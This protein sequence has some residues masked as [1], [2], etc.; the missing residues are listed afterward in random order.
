MRSFLILI[1][2]IIAATEITADTHIVYGGSPVE[3]ATRD[4]PLGIQQKLQHVFLEQCHPEL[5]KARSIKLI[6]SLQ[7][8]VVM[9][10]GESLTVYKL[11]LE[12]ITHQGELEY[13]KLTLTYPDLVFPLA[14]QIEVSELRSTGICQ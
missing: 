8:V 9:G 5:G 10:L 12:V 4:L 14:E 7:E 2:F 6:K 1:I 11:G 3:T 13:I